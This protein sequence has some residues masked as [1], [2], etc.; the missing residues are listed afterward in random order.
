MSKWPTLWE[1]FAQEELDESLCRELLDRMRQSR[2]ARQPRC[3]TFHFNRFEL[4]IDMNAE[5]AVLFDVLEPKG[6]EGEVIQL[7]EFERRL[8]HAAGG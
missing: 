2:A 1:Q 4:C 7:S 5:T 6:S 3:C 8:H